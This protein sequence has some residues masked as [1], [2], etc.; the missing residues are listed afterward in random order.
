MTA[1]MI[2]SPFSEGIRLP[3]YLTQF[4]HRFPIPDPEQEL[5]LIRKAKRGHET[6][7][8]W[9]MIGHVR[10]VAKLAKQY[11]WTLDDAQDLIQEGMLGIRHAVRK[12]DSTKGCKFSTYARGW[13]RGYIRRFCYKNRPK[14]LRLPEKNKSILIGFIDSK[15]SF[16]MPTWK[17]LLKKPI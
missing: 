2:S 7:L 8:S 1:A 5:E 6:S 12:F 4:L 14:Q 13:I 3:D 10:L 17:R 11:A 9:L 16:L 15:T